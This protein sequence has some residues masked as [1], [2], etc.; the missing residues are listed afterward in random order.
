MVIM[1]SDK[2]NSTDRRIAELLNHKGAS[3]IMDNKISDQS[4]KFIVINHHKTFKIT[5]EKGIVIATDA[6]NNFKKQN[7][8]KGIIGICNQDNFNALK[9]FKNNNIPVI[10]C[11]RGA[12]NTFTVSSIAE[13]SV[14]LS[15]QRSIP[16]INGRYIEPCEIRVNI[17]KN[18][19]LFSILAATVTML[20]YSVTP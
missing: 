3:I 9:L 4:G 2:E 6:I 1:L 11:G 18:E 12:K 17:F 13:E 7:F 19:D 16:D 8:P 10:T 5:A 20:I 15:L 14:L